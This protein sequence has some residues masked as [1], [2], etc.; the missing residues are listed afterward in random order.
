MS[1]IEALGELDAEAIQD[2][3]MSSPRGD[4]ATA[5]MI[6]SHV[7]T[8]RSPRSGRDPSI[9]VIKPKKEFIDTLLDK[10][11]REHELDDPE[12]CSSSSAAN[13]RADMRAPQKYTHGKESRDSGR[14]MRIKDDYEP[15]KT[16][17]L[18]PTSPRLST[19]APSVPEGQ[20]DLRGLVSYAG[21][22]D[23]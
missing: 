14:N 16:L 8:A 20:E 11:G 1:K 10:D 7:P 13:L 4:A 3:I 19:L 22:G 9:K 12:L 21:G 15:Q 23:S 6:K 18:S 5:L 2:K 17:G